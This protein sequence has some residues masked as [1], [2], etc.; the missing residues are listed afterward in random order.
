MSVMVSGWVK[1][2]KKKPHS[3]II[4]SVNCDTEN[5]AMFIKNQRSMNPPVKPANDQKM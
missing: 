3:K 4:N 2:Q 5:D 1:I